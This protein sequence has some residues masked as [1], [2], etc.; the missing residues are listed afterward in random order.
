MLIDSYIF[1]QDKGQVSQTQ[2][3][4]ITSLIHTG[5]DLPRDKLTN[6]RPVILL[7]IDYKSQA[8][9]IAAR[10]NRVIITLIAE[11]QCGLIKGRNIATIIRTTDD[12][13]DYLDHENQPGI[14]VGIDFT[15]SFDTISKTLI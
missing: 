4:G 6:W 9:T 13:I 1:S 15:K 11:D 8:K 10:L 14:L 7:N 5:K 12:V 3:R 2:Q